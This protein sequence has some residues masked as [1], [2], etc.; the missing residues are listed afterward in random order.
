[1]RREV[2]KFGRVRFSFIYSHT[3]SSSEYRW[4][5]SGKGS[6]ATTSS[7]S[8]KPGLLGPEGCGSERERIAGWKNPRAPAV[9]K[10]WR[11]GA[12]GAVLESLEDASVGRWLSA[13]RT[14]APRV[15]EAGEGETPEGEKGGPGPP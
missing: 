8:A 1:M 12:T 11:E 2:G 15:E 5:G 7:Q 13:G 9:Q 6:H 14:R 3:I 10:L 4:C